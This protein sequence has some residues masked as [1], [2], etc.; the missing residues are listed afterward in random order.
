MSGEAGFCP[1]C[2]EPHGGLAQRG[3]TGEGQRGATSPG[4]GA[5]LLDIELAAPSPRARPS[6][7]AAQGGELAGG[8]AGGAN[9]GGGIEFD[10]GL[11][12]GAGG[13]EI[14]TGT[15]ERWA[16][17]P[18]PAPS[19]SPSTSE[20][21]P[22]SRSHG[23]ST[24]AAMATPPASRP[25][26]KGAPLVDDGSRDAGASPVPH[27]RASERPPAS[28]KRVL[29]ADIERVAGLGP[30]PEAAWETPFYAARVLSRRRSLEREGAAAR[31]AFD[32]AAAELEREIVALVDNPLRPLRADPAAERL[33]SI[34]AGRASLD[35]LT[36]GPARTAADELATVEAELAQAEQRHAELTRQISD[37]QAAAA[38]VFEAS[39]AGGASAI[40]VAASRRRLSDAEARAL[41]AARATADLR[42]RRKL[43]AEARAAGEGSLEATG[44]RDP[45]HDR[46]SAVA[47]LLASRKQ[48]TYARWPQLEAAY[49]AAD[50]AESEM[51][52]LERAR[53]AHDDE[54]VRKGL[55]I[56]AYAAGSLA[57]LVL[58]G[59]LRMW[60]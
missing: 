37:A 15:V 19:P 57:L 55:T 13:L 58:I 44:P 24:S 38:R 43:A 47:S 8:W 51:A 45:R 10:E 50:R 56:S 2:G 26:P 1:H 36:M 28:T 53:V 32:E 40:E 34:A 42:R 9:F 60:L 59:A 3:A 48:F 52:T 54:A 30:A 35:E 41:D 7:G 29:A 39:K 12:A 11:V 46:W 20:A 49:R 18:A 16:R 33:G 31:R 17:R 21:P 5:G 22:S 27:S 25:T 23:G 14:D 4:S 6:S